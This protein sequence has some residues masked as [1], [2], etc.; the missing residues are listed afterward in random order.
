M[1]YFT[2]DKTLEDK[3]SE[4]TLL[5]TFCPR[6]VTDLGVVLEGRGLRWHVGSLALFF[7]QAFSF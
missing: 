1:K 6:D 3:S 7:F 5:T 2:S 4:I